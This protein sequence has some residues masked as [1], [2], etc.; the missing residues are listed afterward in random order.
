MARPSG[1]SLKLL[2]QYVCV[3]ITDLTVVDIGLFDFDADVTLY[4]FVLN[5]DEQ[6]YLRYGGRDDTSPD[7]YLNEKSLHAALEKGL[8]LHGKWKAGELK[9]PARPAAK[10]PADYPSVKSEVIDRKQCVHCHH[11][12]SGKTKLAASKG[13]LD[14]L[15][16]LWVYPDA[17]NLGLELDADTGITVAKV[18][19][20]AKEA[21][22]KAKDEIVKVTGNAVY[23]WGDLQQRLHEVPHDATSL[24]FTVR[25]KGA[26]T[27][28]EVTLPEWWRATRIERRSFVHA[29]EPFPEFWGRELT[30][31][32]RRKYGVKPGEFGA[33]VT[34][35]WVKTNAQ[36]AGVQVGDIIYEV[37][38]TRSA[39]YTG[40]PAL[41]VRLNR[42]T[43]DTIKVKV[44]RG[45]KNLEF[46][47]KLRAKAW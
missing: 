43:G 15:K 16:D 30:E 31:D 10:K 1:K 27:E 32:E 46:S 22:F 42:K 20:V 18:K 28:L 47:F 13:T 41:W 37:D 8:D 29:A 3:R 39:P 6:V 24:K 2:S 25:R 4:C 19:G 23:T 34:K 40:H 21:G 14:K 5:A 7:A 33:E 17:A 35:F 36:S 44:L 9:L 26:E 38:G 12:G 11:T 45:D